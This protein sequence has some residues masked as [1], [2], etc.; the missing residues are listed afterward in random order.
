MDRRRSS[1]AR[2]LADAEMLSPAIMARA[3]LGDEDDTGDATMRVVAAVNQTNQQKLSQLYRQ[4]SMMSEPNIVSHSIAEL[5]GGDVDT[6]D[7]AMD[8]RHGGM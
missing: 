5:E 2:W 6:A 4:R 7:P 1:T 3:A 8:K